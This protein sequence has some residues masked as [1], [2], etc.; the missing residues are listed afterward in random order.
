VLRLEQ[1]R[2]SPLRQESFNRTLRKVY[3]GHGVYTTVKASNGKN[4]TEVRPT[5]SKMFFKELNDWLD[6]VQPALVRFTI[7]YI[8]S[9]FYHESK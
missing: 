1:K 3:H 5:P 6:L 8:L 4:E 2:F 9:Q 7:R